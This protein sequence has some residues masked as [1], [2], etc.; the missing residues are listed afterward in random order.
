M[1]KKEHDLRTWWREGIDVATEFRRLRLL[2][3]LKRCPGTWYEDDE[4]SDCI[5]EQLWAIREGLA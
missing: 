5:M 2:N 1:K 4:N 3:E